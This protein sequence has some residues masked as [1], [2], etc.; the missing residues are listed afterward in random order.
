MACPQ[1]DSQPRERCGSEVPPW[2]LPSPPLRSQSFPFRSVPYLFEPRVVE[3]LVGEVEPQPGARAG[4]LRALGEC[5]VEGYVRG[6]IVA[7]QDQRL[8]VAQGQ[9]EQLPALAPARVELQQVLQA[10]RAH[11]R[12]SGRLEGRRGAGRGKGARREVLRA[13][14]RTS[15]ASSG[16]SGCGSACGCGGPGGAGGRLVVVDLAAGEAR[17]QHRVPQRRRV[18]R[19][20]AKGGERQARVGQGRAERG[21]A[22]RG[23]KDR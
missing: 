10:P 14:R 9:V 7:R 20:R 19:L 17:L 13:T 15:P 1:H 8:A 6:Q 11:R 5:R 2:A 22:G 3:Q 12:R 21:R 16:N 18:L 4:A 23:G